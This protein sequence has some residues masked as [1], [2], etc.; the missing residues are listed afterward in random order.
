MI[1]III[2]GLGLNIIEYFKKDKNDNNK[3]DPIEIIFKI[4]SEICFCLNVVTNKLNMEKYFCNSYEICIWEGL[5]DLIVI[6]FILL[7]INIIGVTISEIDY[8]QNFYEYIDQFDINDLFLALLTII[9]NGLYN[10]SLII[11]NDIFTPC[12]VLIVLFINELYY[13]FQ[14]KENL[15]LKIL[16]LFV[17]ILLFFTFLF[18][19]EVF[20]LNLFGL[21]KNTKKI[22]K[23]VLIL[24]QK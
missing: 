5:I 24:T 17:L 16:G 23:N 12:H 2:L 1:I 20:E 3:V 8:P 15:M 18:F 4:I 14:L 22:L 6:S 9:I 19:I 11:T 21:S 13:Y 10:M 7:I